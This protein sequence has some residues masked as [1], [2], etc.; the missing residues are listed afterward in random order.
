MNKSKKEGIMKKIAIFL[1][2]C[3]V[4]S[5]CVIAIL[6][7]TGDKPAFA[8]VT[9]TQSKME[10]LDEMVKLY[11][12]SVVPAAKS[13]KGYLGIL[14]LTNRET[15]KSISITIW[16]SEEDAIA[17]EKSGYY[18]EQVDKFK[19]YFTAPPVREGYE[20]SVKD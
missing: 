5:F 19:D 17:N 6:A 7:S 12:E 14:L 11:S 2:A 9:I 20:V 3:L 1:M 13:Q 16:E 18:Q 15:G 10:S 8:R 4:V